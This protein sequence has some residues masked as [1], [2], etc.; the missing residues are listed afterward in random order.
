MRTRPLGK[1]GIDVT[2][3]SLGTWG[4][5]GDGYGAVTADEPRRVIDRACAMGVN[6]FET[7]ASYGRGKIERTLGEALAE[8]DGIV[9]TKWGTDRSSAPPQKRFD[10]EYLRK[11][12][13]G[14]RERLGENTRVIALLHNPLEQTL[15]QG[16]AGQTMAELTEEGLI[17][18]WGV[19]V[20]DEASGRAALE[21]DAPVLSLTHNLLVVQPLRALSS[22]IEEKKTGVLAHSVLFYG[23]LAAKWAPNKT[24]RAPDHRVDR[25][26]E[27]SLRTRIRHLDAIRP[28][29]SGEVKTMTAAAIRFV[30]EEPLVSS[31]V[32]G[33]RNS[34]QLDSAVRLNSV[35]PP[36]LS[37]G[38]LS[39]LEARLSHLGISR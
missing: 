19:S 39:A 5:S 21:A 37:E 20:G 13:E 17:Q 35:E 14:S 10:A 38:K 22:L 31:V 7:S 24:F 36:Y 18:S 34:S 25:W 9:V 12:A 29:V 1:T 28:L 26:P 33:P 15:K 30:L 4:L 6:L 27:G 3:L 11:C 2:E 8:K 32:L 23:L 16:D